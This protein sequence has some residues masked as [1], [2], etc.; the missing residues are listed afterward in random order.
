[1]GGE[2]RKSWTDGASRGVILGFGAAVVA[3]TVGWS[4]TYASRNEIAGLRAELAAVGLDA[5]TAGT[6]RDDIAGAK[7]D[8]VRVENALTAASAAANARA[9]QVEKAAAK[10]QVVEAKALSAT[11]AERA[12]SSLFTTL[13]KENK[14]LEPAVRQLSNAHVSLTAAVGARR[15]ELTGLIAS[16]ER[17]KELV[18]KAERWKVE[19]DKLTAASERLAR[20]V[21]GLENTVTSLTAAIAYRKTELGEALR[22]KA[23]ADEVVRRSTVTVLEH[24]HQLRDLNT[25]IAAMKI[26]RE[27]IGKAIVEANNRLVPALAAASARETQLV[28]LAKRVAAAETENAALMLA[29]QELEDRLDIAETRLGRLADA[30]RAVAG[31]LAAVDQVLDADTVQAAMLEK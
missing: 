26:E 15:T 25:A 24:E 4:E 20:E 3:A 18:S 14:V 17:N 6:L 31:H 1:M 11:T 9:S 19:G 21:V 27:Q 2:T 8:L 28:D 30:A 10:L 23:E 13:D 29:N 16:V 5:S 7:R 22:G 12:A